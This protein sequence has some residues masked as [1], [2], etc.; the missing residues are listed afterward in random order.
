MYEGRGR[1]A[2]LTFSAVDNRDKADLEALLVSESPAQITTS[3]SMWHHFISWLIGER[4]VLKAAN[5]SFPEASASANTRRRFQS[6]VKYNQD[7]NGILFAAH[8]LDYPI[9][10]TEETLQRFS[11]NRTVSIV[12]NGRR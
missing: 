1:I 10:Q 4:V 6:T 9:V 3:L 8:Y 5:F 7:S 11:E 12:G 2:K